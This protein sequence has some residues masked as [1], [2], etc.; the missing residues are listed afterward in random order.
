MGLPPAFWGLGFIV[1]RQKIKRGS[2]EKG[3]RSRATEPERAGLID[4]LPAPHALV[5]C[6]QLRV[7][8][9]HKL[10]PLYGLVSETAARSLRATSRD[11]SRFFRAASSAR[12]SALRSSRLSQAQVVRVK[13][14]TTGISIARRTTLPGGAE[15]VQGT[16]LAQ[17]GPVILEGS[18]LPPLFAVHT[19]LPQQKRGCANATKRNGQKSA[20]SRKSMRVCVPPIEE[21]WGRGCGRHLKCSPCCSTPWR[22]A[23]CGGIILS[24]CR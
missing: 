18:S 9:Y 23:N 1:S 3:S 7:F 19:P 13:L 16:G 22:F 5:V 4:S 2:H 21:C 20:E 17:W 11:F 12:R 15:V 6:A 10:G 8:R 14:H 24:R